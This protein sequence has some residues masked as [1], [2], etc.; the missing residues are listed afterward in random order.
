MTETAPITMGKVLET[1]DVDSY[2]YIRL[3]FDGQEVWLA[4]SPV[5]VEQGDAVQFTGGTMMQDFHST[6]LDRT[7]EQILFVGA[8]ELVDFDAASAGTPMAAVDPHAGLGLPAA[9]TEETIILEL[10]EGGLSIAELFT[11]PGKLEGKQV[12]MRARVI[13]VNASIMGKNWVTLQDG[14]GVAPDNQLTATTQQTVTVGDE[15][16]LTATVRNDID[17]GHGYQYKVLLENA[18]F[19]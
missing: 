14:T 11:D 15:L 18:I 9:S 10:P 1:M 13:K 5:L 12:T 3:G 7:F 4:T 2:T 17:L 6:S 19:E 16:T 8:V